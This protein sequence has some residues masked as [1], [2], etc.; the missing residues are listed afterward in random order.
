MV[1][2]LE[3]NQQGNLQ[4]PLDIL[5]HIKP[6]TRY[7]L[8]V[9]GETLILRPQKGQPFWAIATPAQRAAKFRERATQTKRPI[10][11][12]LPD[13]AFSRETIYN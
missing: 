2:I 3:I 13:E 5:P 11:P 8:E 10:S 4:I 12:T 9:Q 7:R 6:H 1:Y